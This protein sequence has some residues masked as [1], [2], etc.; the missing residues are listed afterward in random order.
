MMQD[1]D[2]FCYDKQAYLAL[3]KFKKQEF[4]KNFINNIVSELHNP[5]LLVDNNYPVYYL[6]SD[7]SIT[8]NKRHDMDPN[9]KNYISYEIIAPRSFFSFPCIESTHIDTYG[10]MTLEECYKVKNLID[11]LM[12]EI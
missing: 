1:K 9:H 10:I 3:N 12:I 6:Y 4:T 5:A 7:G 11:E 8:R 2:I